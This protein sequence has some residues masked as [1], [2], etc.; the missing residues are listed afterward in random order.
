[1]NS[2][3]Q[4]FNAQEVLVI[5]RL[6]APSIR[7]RRKELR[8]QVC[9]QSWQASARCGAPTD[10]GLRYNLAVQAPPASVCIRSKEPHDN[11]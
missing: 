2:D 9:R 6:V 11:T 4:L 7:H 3:D 1:M 8:L 10:K 5:V